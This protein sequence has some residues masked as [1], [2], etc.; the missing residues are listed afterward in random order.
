[1]SDFFYLAK[2][3]NKLRTDS[4]HLSFVRCFEHADNLV[5]FGP[6]PPLDESGLRVRRQG[7]LA[8]RPLVLVSV[9]R[10]H[11]VDLRPYLLFGVCEGLPVGSPQSL[12]GLHL[13]VG[14]GQHFSQTLL[15]QR[16]EPP[17][18]PLQRLPRATMKKTSDNR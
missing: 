2:K 11:L 4:A 10:D 15:V 16:L 13:L 1:M 18:L 7:D 14:L 17:P 8:H 5:V 6:E 3:Y 12:D 9:V